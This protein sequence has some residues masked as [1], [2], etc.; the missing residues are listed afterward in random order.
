MMLFP[1]HWHAAPLGEKANVYVIAATALFFGPSLVSVCLDAWIIAQYRRYIVSSFL[2]PHHPASSSDHK[3]FAGLDSRIIEKQNT[4]LA[5]GVSFMYAEKGHRMQS[6]RW[7]Q[8]EKVNER[9]TSDGSLRGKKALVDF[10]GFGWSISAA[11]LEVITMSGSS[12]HFGIAV[13]G[14]HSSRKLL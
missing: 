10:Y 2:K 4:Q 13:N 3:G 8:P 5:W 1:S 6:A 11:V 14:L 12:L 9:A 7:M